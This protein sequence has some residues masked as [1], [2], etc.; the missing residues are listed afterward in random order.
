MSKRANLPKLRNQESNLTVPGPASAPL[1]SIFWIFVVISLGMLMIATIRRNQVYRTE[2]SVWQD[3]TEKSPRKQRG[4]LNLGKVLMEADPSAAMKEFGVVL[5]LPDPV[6]VLDGESLKV[7]A[8]VNMTSIL[9]ESGRSADAESMIERYGLKSDSLSSNL[10]VAQ[11][12]QGFMDA[13]RRTL[14]DAA[15]RWPASGSIAANLG[16]MERLS[17]NC[18]EALKWYVKSAR[19]QGDPDFR[20]R[21]CIQAQS[22]T[23]GGPSKP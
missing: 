8:L 6:R 11:M 21:E 20:G 2:Q 19:Q 15:K 9:I 22:V 3:V 12:R 13:A 5:V 17:G 14:L 7:G 10:A 4:H 1:S 16:E 23:S 18:T